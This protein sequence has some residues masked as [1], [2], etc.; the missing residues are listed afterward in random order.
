[1]RNLSARSLRPWQVFLALWTLLSLACGAWVITTP[2]AASPDEPAHLVKAASVVRGEFLGDV[3]DNPQ[4]REVD[5]PAYIAY[6]YEATCYAFMPNVTASCIDPF[7]EDPDAI[8][9]G[10]TSAG[11]YNPVYYLLVG[12]PSLFTDGVTSMY[13]MRAVS[14][15]LC[16]FFLA[17]SFTLLAFRRRPLLPLLAGAVVTTPM[18]LFLSASVNP[19]ALETTTALAFLV[20]LWRASETWLEERRIGGWG[21]VFATVAAV[22]LV[23]TRGLSPLWA[24]LIFAAVVIAVGLQAFWSFLRQA[25]V[26]IA[27]GVI[28]LAGAFAVA[29]SLNTN[30]LPAVGVYAGAGESAGAGFIKMM[31]RTFD[32]AAG[33]VGLFGWVDTP[34]PS[35]VVIVWAVTAGAI[36][37]GAI[38]LCRGRALGAVVFLLAAFLF[39][40]ALI[41]SATVTQS[42][43]IWQGRYTLPLFVCL[44][45]VAALVLS[46][47]EVT[48]PDVG[49]RLVTLVLTLTAFG[50]IAS[51]AYTLKRYSLGTASTWKQFLLTPEWQP[52]GGNVLWIAVFSLAY[53]AFAIVVGRLALR[54]TEPPV[55]S[56]P[57]PDAALV[58]AR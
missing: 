27:G 31:E 39:A 12:W 37:A 30:S 43:Y 38:I 7:T 2:V 21:L 28:A 57:A 19:N 23:N 26:L 33:M 8:V 6:T 56:V 52:P 51:F 47:L 45:V 42:G 55:E 44:V 3:T 58:E 18:L 29:W 22:I 14:A 46:R 36:V 1:L 5:V 48:L 32:Y 34:A 53:V 35:Y 13:L 16:M 20:G 4:V 15:V 24:V 50:Q 41:Q 40:P 49:G 11:L 10:S 17:G 54:R 9:E 25:R